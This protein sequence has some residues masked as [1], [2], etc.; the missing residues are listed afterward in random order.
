ME[1]VKVAKRSA[2]PVAHSFAVMN[3]VFGSVIAATR[4][5]AVHADQKIISNATF[6]AARSSTA[7]SAMMGKIT[8]SLNVWTAITF[9]VLIA[10]LLIAGNMGWRDATVVRS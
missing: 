10:E 7:K 5:A 2:I 3:I 8:I 1:C 9:L 6:R 4:K